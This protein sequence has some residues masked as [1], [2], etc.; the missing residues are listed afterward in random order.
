MSKFYGKVGYVRTEEARPGIIVEIPSERAYYGDVIN[1]SS[2]WDTNGR[3]NEDI[4]VT[5]K[6]SILADPY[7]YEHFSQLRYVEYMGAKWKITSISVERP[8]LVLTLGGL[9]NG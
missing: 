8:R 3:V 7:A 9:Y 1:I 5:N 2:K 4:T 6:I